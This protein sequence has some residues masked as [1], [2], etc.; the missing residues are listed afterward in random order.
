MS[1]YNIEYFLNDFANRTMENLKYIDR[2]SESE[3]LFEITQLIN[4][5]LG[6]IIV[7]V[8]AYKHYDFSPKSKKMN[9]K[10]IMDKYNSML[11]KISYE[12]YSSIEKLIKKCKDNNQLYSDYPD[13]DGVNQFIKHIRNSVAHGGNKGLHFYPISE[14]NLITDIFFYD[15]MKDRYSDN[16]YEFCVKISVSDLK[17]LIKCISN[18]YCRFE[19]KD[20]KVSD[21][22]KKYSNDIA[23][24]NNL[25]TC[26]RSDKTKTIF[27]FENNT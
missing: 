14:S 12:D 5:M 15:N 23:K 9:Y 16:K 27:D 3:N 25:I 1:S 20:K 26:G 13:D 17:E 7:P 24:L 4:S 18:L 10:E 8:E 2:Y 11:K 22:Q 21:K 6:L 19:N